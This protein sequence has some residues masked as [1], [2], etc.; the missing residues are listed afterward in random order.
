MF[1][2]LGTTTNVSY[3]LLGTLA[4]LVSEQLETFQ[5][6]LNQGV[7]DFPS[8]PKSQ[9]ENATRLATVDMMVQRYHDDGTVKITLEILRK[10]GQNKL[11]IELKEKLTN[12][13]CF[14]HCLHVSIYG[15]SLFPPHCLHVDSGWQD[16]TDH[17]SLTPPHGT[18][19]SVH[20][21]T[22]N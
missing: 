7:E 10:M 5:W 3:L 12:E 22:S 14:L 4:E 13:F 8:I 2:Y 6:H 11:A 9:L 17:P 1:L 15:T 20:S 16:S 19:G 18:P 21:D